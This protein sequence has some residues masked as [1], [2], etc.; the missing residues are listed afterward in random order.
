LYPTTLWRAREIVRDQHNLPLS[1]DLLPG[2][3]NLQVT[4]QRSP[5]GE[6]LG[7]LLTLTSITL[8]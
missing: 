5:G 6:S 3:Y 8:Q 7:P 1:A 4:V 2:R